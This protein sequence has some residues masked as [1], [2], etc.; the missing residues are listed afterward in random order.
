[1][2]SADVPG[3]GT[4]FLDGV[5]EEATMQ[6]ILAAIQGQQGGGSQAQVSAAGI[7]QVNRGFINLARQTES[8]GKDV[9]EG[10]DTAYQG[11]IK[12][13]QAG[14]QFSRQLGR[15]SG[16][17][18]RSFET[19][20]ESPFGFAKAITNIAADLSKDNKLAGAG[21]G[22]IAGYAASLIG[23]FDDIGT[24]FTTAFGA[25]AGAIA[26]GVVAGATSAIAGFI[27]EKL[28]STSKAFN[29]V[30]QSGAIL[31]GSLIEF[32]KAAHSSNLTMAEYNN[33]MSKA[34]DSMSMFGG[35]TLRGARE[36]ARTNQA[37]TNE[38]ST[39]LL[40]MGYSF[41]DMGVATAEMMERFTLSGMSFDQLAV[42]T[43]EVAA[44]AFE[45]AQQ[46]K[47]LA[48]MTGRSIEQ[49]K[50]A[51]KAQRQDAQVQAAIARLGPQQ[52]QQV[53]QL[54]SA[55]PH[56]R[57]AILDQV[58]FGGA[59]GE[60]AMRQL[61]LFPNAVASVQGA[62]DGIKN[63]SG[64][65]IDAFKAQA[66]NSEAIRAEYLEGADLVAQLGRYSSNQLVKTAE[67]MIIPQQEM[68]AKAIGDTVGKI[69]DDMKTLAK[70][71]GDATK[72]LIEQ[73][74]AQRE[75]NMQISAGITGLLN[76]TGGL[77]TK[78]T[79]LTKLTS[80]IV[81]DVNQGMGVDTTF[82]ARQNDGRAVPIPGSRP[83]APATSTTTTA[84]FMPDESDATL[85]AAGQQL[86]AT[87]ATSAINNNVLGAGMQT[88]PTE[89]SD[90]GV[91]NALTE[92][93]K[94][95]KQS[96]SYLRNLAMA[97]GG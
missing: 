6:R 8:T 56:L 83:S 26:P 20:S 84:M 92:L 58:T 27:F 44:A 39:P 37:L 18:V 49:Q 50:A 64:I 46:Q 80:G 53:E 11:M 22:M 78:V 43:R 73:Q 52:Q 31:G 76:Q 60:E 65:A 35:Q 38:F 12:A 75:L 97:A 62:V 1:L 72:A 14:S 15:A 70:G 85:N 40:Q 86:A 23:D 10:G 24:T 9:R 34:S 13:G 59:V 74:K 19:A 4:V 57:G 28:D 33:V 17:L 69:V 89:T 36:F 96:N 5:A 32:R 25:A 95:Q 87:G 67:Q 54:I 42:R 16:N 88:G 77:I 66:A 2:A 90:P 7:S 94:Q 21:V 63:G 45:Q 82:A 91:Q 79:E 30:Q 71:G 81:A 68:M 93:L 47:V 61:T 41:E 51:Q 3:I 55:F 48:A 29:Q